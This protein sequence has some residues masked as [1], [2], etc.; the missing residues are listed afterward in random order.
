MFIY[1]YIAID[2][3]NNLIKKNL[4]A[5]SK[6]NA[7]LAI[8][9]NNLTP[10][11]I[12]FKM[13]F[14]LNRENIDYRIHF[15]HQLSI[16]TSSGINLV[17]CLKILLSNCHLPYWQ[18]MIENSIENL[19]KGDKLSQHLTKHPLI[20]NNTIVSLIIVAEKTGRYDESFQ[21]IS[22]MLEHNEK[23]ALL[24]KKAIRYPIALSLFSILL[25]IIMMYYVV[26]QFESIYG[27][28]QHELPF[29]TKVV[30]FTSEYIQ[31]KSIIL[32]FIFFI[33]SVLTVK[34]K[35]T[36]KSILNRVMMRIPLL[37]DLIQTHYLSL[38]FLTMHSTLRVGLSLSECLNCTIQTISNY[39]YNKD[40]RQI[41]TSVHQGEL[42]SYA[43]KHTKFFPDLSVQL[44]SIAEESGK[45]Q[46]FTQYL[47]K[48][49]S[50]QYLFLTEKSLK[51]LEPILLVFIAI[52]VG[53]IMLA[54]YLPIFNLG[55][56]ITGL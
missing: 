56:V 2:S 34:F 4:L 31:E 9:K 41:Q 54:M 55:N 18:N 43:M 51:N 47:F 8:T 44:L 40:C 14:I 49:Y 22:T 36:L 45:L 33:L 24:I 3:N 21:V 35:F 23:N 17:Q 13:I 15:F 50:E 42:L 7:F 48:Y 20:F 11:K 5:S 26:P 37:K 6:K 52:L 25:L 32:L 29:V 53:T 46:Y 30:I 1:S 27:N 38:Y 19:E 28:F 10:L 39:Q 16:L 12:K